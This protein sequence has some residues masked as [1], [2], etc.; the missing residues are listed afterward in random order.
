MAKNGAS[1]KYLLRLKPFQKVLD[2]NLLNGFPIC[3][4]G[5]L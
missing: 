3:R 4:E 2:V 5:F 1:E